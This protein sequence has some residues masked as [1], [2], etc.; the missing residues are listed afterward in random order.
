MTPLLAALMPGIRTLSALYKA[1]YEELQ[2]TLQGWKAQS[3]FPEFPGDNFNELGV[4]PA[5]RSEVS[6]HEGLGLLEGSILSLERAMAFAADNEE[7]VKS[8]GQLLGFV[9]NLRISP[10]VPNPQDQFKVF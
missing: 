6:G 7:Q 5:Y 10:P 8:L 9:Q 1:N 2:A 3:C 4:V